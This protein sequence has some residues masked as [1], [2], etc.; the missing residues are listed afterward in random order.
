MM[1]SSSLL[2][3]ID[4]QLDKLFA[5]WNIY[6]T[7]IFLLITTILILP[8]VLSREPDTHPFL[9][10][11]QSIPSPVRQPGES[12]IYRSLE[13]PF[14]YPLRSGLNV[15]DPDAPKWASGKDGDLRDIWRQAVKGT[16]GI[17]GIEDG[18]HGTVSTILGKERVVEHT[19]DQLSREINAVGTHVTEAKIERLAICLA[20]SAELLVALF[21][22]AY[23]NFT[24][25]IVPPEC[26]SSLLI[27]VLRETM[28]DG[29]V[30][31]AGARSLQDLAHEPTL[32]KVILVV[33]E[34]SRHMDFHEVPATISNSI[35]VAVWDKIIE[36]RKR[37][38]AELPV[39]GTNVP[40]VLMIWQNSV[41]EEDS[42]QDH[43]VVL[44]TQKVSYLLI[45][46]NRAERCLLNHIIE[47][48]RCRS[49]P[50][51]RSA[52][53]SSSRPS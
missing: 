18:R 5:G 31:A 35:E 28:A 25:I 11:R 50:T 45:F 47:F 48:S 23:Y 3:Q 7:L 53:Y 1:E 32:K 34:S 16:S 52:S 39:S 51:V 40:D 33:E 6:T 27:K 14:G 13:T 20:N 44:F 46:Y 22:A 26:S 43:E 29:L 12:A 38:S 8:V 36:D 42:A 17:D 30:V 19:L 49:C 41:E 15:K 10:A 4:A 21:A 24:P 2:A 9:L 37:D